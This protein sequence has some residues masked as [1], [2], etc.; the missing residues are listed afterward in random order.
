M[1]PTLYKYFPLQS[2][3]H[4]A[5]LERVFQGWIHFTSPLH[6]N[7]PF[8]MSPLLSPPSREDFEDLV[9]QVGIQ[10]D[11]LTRSAREKVFRGLSTRIKSLARPAV[12]K[13][14]IQTLGV[15][16]LTSKA[17]NLLMWAHYASNHTGIC[18]GFDSAV[19]PFESARAVR[20][21]EERPC[22]R[23]IDL[24]RDD[25]NLIEKV[26]FTKSPH[27]V[28]EFEWRCIKRAIKDEEL[29]YYKELIS[30]EP[31]RQSEIADLLVTEGGPGQYEFE[32]GAV[33]RIYLGA[34]INPTYRERLIESLDRFSI[35]A[36]LYQMSLDP[37]YFRLNQDKIKH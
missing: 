20:Y 15:L 10:P 19:A 32:A 33:R 17:E 3:E 36:R 18:I 34:K 37:R 13:D 12:T 22:V 9:D 14:W 23:A 7:D 21:Q 1:K 5:R 2:E 25:E 27:W 16:C 11:R 8:E 30:A 31:H 29:L 26:L 4:F 35:K 28:Y 24:S 6:F